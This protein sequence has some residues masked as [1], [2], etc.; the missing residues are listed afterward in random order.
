[1]SR[2]KSKDTSLE[3]MMT[4]ALTARGHEFSRHRKDL[5]GKPDIVFEPKLPYLLMAIFGTAID[6][7]LG[8]KN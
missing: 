8:K 5:P 1:M 3:L 4:N 6:T 2:V 7:K